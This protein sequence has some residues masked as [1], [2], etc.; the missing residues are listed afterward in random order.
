MFLI[1]FYHDL[2]DFGIFGSMNQNI[3]KLEVLCNFSGPKLHAVEL[4]LALSSGPRISKGSFD[5]FLTISAQENHEI[6]EP[7]IKIPDHEGLNVEMKLMKPDEPLRHLY[8][9]IPHPWLPSWICGLRKLSVHTTNELP[10]FLR[11]LSESSPASS[12]A[13]PAIWQWLQPDQWNQRNQF[14]DCHQRDQC[15]Q[16]DQY[17]QC[18]GSAAD[19]QTFP[20]AILS[21]KLCWLWLM[22][23][24]AIEHML[25]LSWS[26]V[27]SPRPPNNPCPAS[28]SPCSTSCG[29]TTFPSARM[30]CQLL[31]LW[32][33]PVRSTQHLPVVSSWRVSSP[34]AP[35]VATNYS[36]SAIE[37]TW[38]PGE[39]LRL[40]DL[41]MCSSQ[42]L[43]VVPWQFG[44]STSASATASTSAEP[45]TRQSS[46][47][48]NAWLP[49]QLLWLWLLRMCASRHLSVV[50]RIFFCCC[51][52]GKPLRWSHTANLGGSIVSLDPIRICSKC[53][54]HVKLASWKRA[55][56]SLQHNLTCTW[57]NMATG[58]LEAWTD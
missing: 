47:F 41:P 28:T 26:L 37:D 50:W 24:C 57:T 30:P 58:C 56:Y 22:C 9:A 42:H 14:D 19:F 12:L 36:S 23:L 1:I 3:L 53:H 55:I 7:S 54:L 8:S 49:C 35:T 21:S 4:R 38:L 16:R 11:N 46:A 25:L 29:S 31:R 27:S 18:N 13:G 6:G 5:C 40:R 2:S 15:D 52:G 20:G 45:I 34:S 32:H 10:N 51:R 48:Q 39:L 43:P 17:N 33:V 44:T